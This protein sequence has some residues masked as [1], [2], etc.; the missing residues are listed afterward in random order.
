MVCFFFLNNCVVIPARSSLCFIIFAVSLKPES[1]VR[2]V[3][4]KKMTHSWYGNNIFNKQVSTRIKNIRMCFGI[5]KNRH[6]VCAN[7]ILIMVWY[8]NILSSIIFL[9]YTILVILQCVLISRY[10]YTNNSLYCVCS[11]LKRIQWNWL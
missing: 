8:K 7:K 6:K 10:R 1:R 4:K 9:F 3:Y 2:T 5:I 11:Q